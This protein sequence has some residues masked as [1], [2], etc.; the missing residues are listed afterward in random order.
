MSVL[1][2]RNFHAGMPM[3]LSVEP[4]TSCNLRCPEC[5]S[6]L[7]E[8]TRPQGMM[9]LAQFKQIVNQVSQDLVYL[10]FYFQGEPL[11]N[12]EFYKMLA[13]AKKKRIYTA[14]SS[15]G[16][17]LD[18]E[19]ARKLIE[20]GLDRMIISMDGTDQETYEKYR[21]GGDLKTVKS[22]VENILKWRKKLNSRGPFIIIQFLVFK[23]NEHQ[24]PEMKKLARE[25]GA[26]KL[27]FKSAQ[28]MDFKKETERIPDIKKFSRYI[29]GADGEWKPKK[30]MR[31][32][33]FRM[34]SGAVIT[35]D[36]RVVPCCFDKDAR[37]LLGKLGEQSFVEIWRG[38]AYNDFRNQVLTNRKEIVIC[39]N[40]TE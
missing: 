17:F 13:Y 6:G 11:L 27:E 12:P 24:I 40:C 25:L 15:N 16:H 5:P 34:W 30:R 20:S 2:G 37:Y 36:G 39:T 21:S 14:T 1:A 35:W 3:S 8:F 28:V 19:N 33:C 22:G 7:R 26:D 31:N 23:H 9:S 4:T 32:R 18:D 29:R 38:K 10:M